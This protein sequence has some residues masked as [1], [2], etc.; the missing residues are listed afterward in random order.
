MELCFC[1]PPSPSA[2]MVKIS[3]NHDINVQEH[4]EGDADNNS[5]NFDKSPTREKQKF[6]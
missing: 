4:R 5:R 1:F 3:A 2:F 6:S